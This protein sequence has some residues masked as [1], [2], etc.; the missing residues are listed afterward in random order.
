MGEFEYT[1]MYSDGKIVARGMN[2]T[3]ALT[4]VEALFHK[5]YLEPDLAVTI[6]RED[7]HCLMVEEEVAEKDAF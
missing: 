2:L 3:D 5:N 7:P 6:Q 4:L 1:V